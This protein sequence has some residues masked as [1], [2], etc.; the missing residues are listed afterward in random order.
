MDV[1]L[2]DQVAKV[3]VS[4]TFVNTGSRQLDEN[5]LGARLIRLLDSLDDVLRR[6]AGDDVVDDDLVD[7]ATGC[8]RGE[9]ERDEQTSADTK[10]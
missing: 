4:Q 5:D 1:A 3:Q 2:K 7:L 8:R 10:P 9:S 6:H